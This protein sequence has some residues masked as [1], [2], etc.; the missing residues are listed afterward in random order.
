MRDKVFTSGIRV[1][2]ETLD[3]A[4][5]IKLTMDDIAYLVPKCKHE[6]EHPLSKFYEFTEDVESVCDVMVTTPFYN[7][8]EEQVRTYATLVRP[9]LSSKYLDSVVGMEMLNHAPVEISN[10]EADDFAIYVLP[11]KERRALNK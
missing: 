10:E 8:L 3:K 5:K 2:T 9:V 1:T 7:W 4:I 6:E 11:E